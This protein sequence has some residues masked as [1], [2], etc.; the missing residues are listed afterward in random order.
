[1]SRQSA[2]FTVA[3]LLTFLSTQVVYTSAAEPNKPTVST[4]KSKSKSKSKNARRHSQKAGKHNT[5]G[6][7]H[8]K[9]TDK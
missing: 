2:L 8:T 7:S 9:N 1:M 5:T 6:T 4:Q 3:L